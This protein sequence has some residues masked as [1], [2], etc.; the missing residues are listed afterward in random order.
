MSNRR[1]RAAA[2]LNRKWKAFVTEPA[3]VLLRLEQLEE[4][5]NPAP[6]ATV[7][8]LGNVTP[9]LGETATFS[10]TFTNTDATDTGFSP[11][12]DLILETSGPDG[13]T[14]SPPTS[15]NPTTPAPAAD[16][17]AA[18]SGGV[19]NPTVTVSGLTLIPI[20]TPIVLTA[21]QTTYVNPFTSQTLSVPAGYGAGDTIFTY[22]LPF[23]SFTPGQSTLA[24][25]SAPTSNLADVGTPLDLT[26]RPGFRDTDGNP[27]APLVPTPA[28]THLDASAAAIPKLYDFTKTYVGPENETATGPNYVRRYRLSVDIAAGQTIQ[29]LVITDNLG[30]TMQLAG[31]TSANMAAF[32][33]SSGLGTNVFNAANRGGTAT[34][35]APDGTVTY[36]FGNVTGVAGTDAVFEFDFFVP[37]DD[38][39]AAEILPQPTPPAPNP[40][41]GTDSIL[42]TNTA[43]T[44]GTWTPLDSRDAPN[45]NVA[46]AAPD[47]G[48]HTL[49]EHSVAVQ[50]SVTQVTVASPNTPAGGPLLPGV[51]L[52]RYT[53]DFQ[54]SDYY[55]VNN[56][57]LEDVLGDGQ[58]L[59]LASGF[60]P[61]LTVQN[62]W[63]F[64][65]GGER[66]ATSTGAFAGANTIDFERR[67]SITGSTDSDPSAGVENYAA[68]GPTG[69]P[70]STPTTGTIDGTTFLRFNISDELIARGLPGVL[71][72]GEIADGGGNP[73][74]LRN[75]PFG[76][77]RG[78]IT[79]WALVKEEY[80]DDLPSGDNSVDQGDTL[81]NGVPL[82]QGD[83]LSPTDLADGT[84]TALGTT[85]TDD[86]GTSVTV[87]RGVQTKT[88]YAINTTLIPAQTVADTVFSVQAGDRVTYKLTYTLPISRFEDLEIL[89]I[90]P[91]PVMAVGP[92]AQ[93]TFD[94]T[95]DGSFT[96]Y[97]IEVAPDD[98]FFS[99]FDGTSGNP[100][101]PSLVPGTTITTNATTNTITMSFG[102]FD[103]PQDR[104]TTISLLVTL[105]VSA[106]PFIGDL[107]LTN[108][109]RVNEGNTFLGTTTVEDL[110]RI[111]LVRPQLTVD[112]G[113]VGFGATGRALGG[114]TFTAP[115]DPPTG[116]SVPAFT[117]TIDTAAEADAVGAANV[118]ASDNV[119]AADRVRYAIVAQN[120]GFGDAYDV[121]IEDQVQPGYVIPATFAGLN[122]NVRHGDG[123]LLT[124]FAEVQGFARVAT[125]GA[126]A[127]ATFTT[128]A[129]GTFT[130]V[131]RTLDG[132]ILNVN[133]FVL[134]KDQGTA[135]QNGVYRVSA[136]D[137]AANTVTLVRAAAFDTAAELSNTF[138]A[139]MGGTSANRYFQAGAVATL[140]TSAVNYTL[141]AA[142]QDYYAIYDP[143]T[144]AFRLLLSDN[145]TAGNVSNAGEV[146]DDRAG[147][148]SRARATP[149][150]NAGDTPPVTPITNGSNT[151][152][153]QYDLI[154]ASTV[155]PNQSIVNTARV[156]SYGTSEGGEDVTEPANVPG[157]TDPTD[158]AT[159][160]VKLPTNVK[161]LVGTSVTET[162]NAALN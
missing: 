96:P 16:G 69:G 20:G 23:G 11:F 121:V 34:A 40:A 158:T 84:P 48:P 103:D 132:V 86:S 59:Y 44:A 156:S 76:P 119:D 160:I 162:G 141:Q 39:S 37:R 140:N 89:D 54:I 29:N 147:G 155:T 135:S 28:G 7:T 67:Y 108:Q 43:S 144:G 115:N 81:E 51:S 13:T 62:P 97:E 15:L 120:T 92:A 161:T 146:P 31:L 38:S 107:F 6:V 26:V 5:E 133:E 79:F 110:R 130:D 30:P 65:N 83:H 134:V 116:A 82:I 88:V 151:V 27:N 73:Q 117:G 55:A 139:V 152:V 104:F 106:D 22:Q 127:G 159:A 60:G 36:S 145:Y 126:L 95:F 122:L 33:A 17:F 80:S 49:Q 3:D 64:A 137:E 105:P 70:F 42:D 138:V 78:L 157:G 114:H 52:L 46:K 35:T 102:D 99:T 66:A 57:F 8:G 63:T 41:G 148:I 125:T 129:G 142:T 128:T 93:Y 94:R 74:N 91:L 9:F 100:L 153:V 56:L 12:F 50:K 71:V 19:V 24:S 75:P 136:V 111:Q 143:T 87:P 90:P 113:I 131:S 109:L 154:V 118:A 47:N 14:N 124:N 149:L 61:T 25:V 101:F 4:R 2:W 123:T 53:I 68:T 58:R 150:V 21:G 77:A 98:T 1:R 18:S 45:Q 72:G 10:F 85:G 112:K 32:L